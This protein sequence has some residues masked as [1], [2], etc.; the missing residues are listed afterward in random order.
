MYGSN[1][2]KAPKKILEKRLNA[3]FSQ[4][5]PMLS[6]PKVCPVCSTR[7]SKIQFKTM[8]CITGVNM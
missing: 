4:L 8:F 7:F 6:C 2:R 3:T 1:L 5:F